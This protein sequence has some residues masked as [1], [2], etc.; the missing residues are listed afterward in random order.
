MH[1]WAKL[2]KPTVFHSLDGGIGWLRAMTINEWVW[3]EYESA[4][5]STCVKFGVKKPDRTGVVVPYCL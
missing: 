2:R 5:D 3:L 1:D 4:Q